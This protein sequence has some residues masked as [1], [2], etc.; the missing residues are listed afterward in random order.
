MAR[1]RQLWARR[2]LSLAAC[3][4]MRKDRAKCNSNSRRALDARQ[5]ITY[6]IDIEYAY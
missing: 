5:Y 3:I 1:A 6:Y 2:S 4:L